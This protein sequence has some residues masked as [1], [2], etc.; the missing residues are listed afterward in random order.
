MSPRIRSSQPAFG[1]ATQLSRP[2]STLLLA[3][4][5]VL[6]VLA[7]TDTPVSPRPFRPVETVEEGWESIPGIVVSPYLLQSGDRQV[8]LAGGATDLL[9]ELIG[10]EIV[11][12]GFIDTADGALV[13]HRFTV[14]SVN[15]IPAL[16]GVLQASESGYYIETIEMVS[17]PDVPAELTE[18]VGKRVWLTIRDD[19]FVDFGLLEL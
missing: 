2:R 5:S 11:V 7:C 18:H 17:L 4:S 19:Q 6:T 15:G 12:E 13:I 8:L 10:A 14:L 1:F 3:L 16:D 9:D